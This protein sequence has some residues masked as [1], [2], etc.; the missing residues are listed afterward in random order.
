M[1][2]CFLDALCTMQHRRGSQVTAGSN[3]LSLVQAAGPLELGR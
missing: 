3:Y 1:A 2:A